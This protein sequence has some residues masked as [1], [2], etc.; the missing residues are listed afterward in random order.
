MEIGDVAT[1]NLTAQ[2]MVDGVSFVLARRFG[3]SLGESFRSIFGQAF[4]G[5][6]LKDALKAKMEW[7]EA[8]KS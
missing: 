6:L 1:Y 8:N 5:G 2:A 4:V 7:L 3:V